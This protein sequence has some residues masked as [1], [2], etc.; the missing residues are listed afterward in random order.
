M[1]DLHVLFDTETRAIV[2]ANTTIK[3]IYSLS[4]HKP[5]P[6]FVKVSDFKK[7]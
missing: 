3:I 1:A 7:H 5:A 4:R 6:I 2:I